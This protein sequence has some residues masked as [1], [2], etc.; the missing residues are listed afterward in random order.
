MFVATRETPI[1]AMSV[2]FRPRATI[3][4]LYLTG[5][6]GGTHTHTNDECQ[7]PRKRLDL[8]GSMSTDVSRDE[9]QMTI[10]FDDFGMR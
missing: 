5:A 8:V 2:A 1:A 9:N 7:H 6:Q 4:T 10:L 3:S